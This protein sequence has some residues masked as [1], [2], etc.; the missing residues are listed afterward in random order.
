MKRVVFTLLMV[1]LLSGC[2]VWDKR[3]ANTIEQK[4][5]YLLK[6]GTQYVPHYLLPQSLI[7]PA[8]ASIYTVRN[9][10][11]ND[12]GE[13]SEFLNRLV[14][15][16]FNSG[17]DNCT[18]AMYYKEKEK[19]EGKRQEIS[20]RN[21]QVP[22]KRGDLF[23]C[24]V[25]F[26][27]AGGPID[28]SGM[29]VRVK[30]NVDRVGFMFPNDTQFISPPLSVVNPDSGDRFGRSADGTREVAASYDGHSYSIT[31]LDDTTMRRIGPGG[32]ETYTSS[33]EMAGTIDVW[34]CDKVK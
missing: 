31:L 4:R 28:S 2:S 30:D 29:R 16:C 11:V 6:Y 10:L 23:Y 5:D 34:G 24:R 9:Q 14:G 1:S 25:T 27:Q 26:N 20:E 19:I 18:I 32:I 7:P 33:L 13:T 12:G 21:K 8:P 15:S 22:V 17:D 3:E